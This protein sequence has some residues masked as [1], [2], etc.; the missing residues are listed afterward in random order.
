MGSTPAYKKAVDNRILRLR[1]SKSGPGAGQADEDEKVPY[2]SVH[3]A[4]ESV[5]ECL[6][7]DFPE[8]QDEERNREA[9]DRIVYLYLILEEADRQMPYRQ[10][11][12]PSLRL[13]QGVLLDAFVDPD[14]FP[15][16]LPKGTTLVFVNANDVD[17]FVRVTAFSR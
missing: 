12:F 5:V 10:F 4:Q 2:Q 9:I 17:I 7:F 14:V 3:Y 6:R 8:T 11:F 13:G 1:P 16:N 15:L